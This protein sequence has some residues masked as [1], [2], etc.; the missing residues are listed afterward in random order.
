LPKSFGFGCQTPALVI[1]EP[2]ALVALLF[3]KDTVLF[4]DVFDHV[5]LSLVYPSGN[6][7]QCEPEWIQNG[8]HLVA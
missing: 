3:A 4:A 8:R 2:Q 7:N 5:Q 6:S 1:A